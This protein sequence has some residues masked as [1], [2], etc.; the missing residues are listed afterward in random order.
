MVGLSEFVPFEA[1][2][3]E[4]GRLPIPKS[5]ISARKKKKKVRVRLGGLFGGPLKAGIN[6]AAFASPPRAD[7]MDSTD[8]L[9]DLLSDFVNK[10]GD[11][12][13]GM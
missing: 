10:K 9:D 6:A 4:P 13:L 2:R 5:P 8:R 3:A 11:W 1:G 12:A 7:P